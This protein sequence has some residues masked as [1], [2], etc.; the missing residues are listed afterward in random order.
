[1][2]RWNTVDSSGALFSWANKHC[3]RIGSRV[4]S[5]L[6]TITFCVTYGPTFKKYKRIL[7]ILSFSPPVMLVHSPKANKI[8]RFLNCILLEKFY[9]SVS[10]LWVYIFFPLSHFDTNGSILFITVLYLCFFPHL[11]EFVLEVFPYH[12]DNFLW[13]GC[14]VLLC[15]DVS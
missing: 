11:Y 7:W 10:K 9:A 3:T 4:S 14:T 13:S 2:T 8:S 15:R 6:S 12:S 1:M 5:D